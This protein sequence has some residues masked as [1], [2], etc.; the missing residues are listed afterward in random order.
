MAYTWD[1]E[2]LALK[3]PQKSARYKS[4][5]RVAWQN[6]FR[7]VQVYAN[8]FYPTIQNMQFSCKTSSYY[9]KLSLKDTTA[10]Q[11]DVM[12]ANRSLC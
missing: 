1:L 5:K 7:H 9:M 2:V 4:L 6:M 12:I 10:F 11:S 3:H 8:L